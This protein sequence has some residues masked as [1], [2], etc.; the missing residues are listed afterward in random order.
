MQTKTLRRRSFN[1]YAAGPKRFPPNVVGEAR[2]ELR[3][4]QS[5]A[6]QA[7]KA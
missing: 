3:R 2:K 5:K 4:R 1:Y 7:A 6:K